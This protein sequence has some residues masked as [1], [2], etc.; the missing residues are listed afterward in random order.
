[1]ANLCESACN[2]IGANGLLARVGCYYHDIGKLTAPGFFVENQGGARTRTTSCRQPTPP[3][4][5]ASTCWTG[6]RSRRTPGC[7]RS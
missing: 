5:S 3:G 4:S 2:I 6:S 1:M 7:R